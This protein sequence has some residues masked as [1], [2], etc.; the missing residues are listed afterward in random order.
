MPVMSTS[1]F[2]VNIQ[3]DMDATRM[4]KNAMRY[5]D[6]YDERKH[7]RECDVDMWRV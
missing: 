5:H 2:M 3:R 6:G 7:C 1:G 4:A